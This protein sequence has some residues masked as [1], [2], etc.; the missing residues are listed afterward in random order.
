MIYGKKGVED[1]FKKNT[2]D[3]AIGSS[4]GLKKTKMWD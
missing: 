2:G 3:K 1:T 4:A